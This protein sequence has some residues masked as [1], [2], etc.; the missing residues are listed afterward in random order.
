[1]I[2]MNR[3]SKFWF[4]RYSGQHLW[5]VAVVDLA[6]IELCVD[7]GLVRLSKNAEEFINRIKR[8][9]ANA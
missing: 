8:E 9:V 1:M 4:G 3:Y 2:R 7:E 6:Y 5:R